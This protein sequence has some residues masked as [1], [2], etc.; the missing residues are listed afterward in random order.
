MKN[1]FFLGVFLGLCLALNAQYIERKN[2]TYKNVQY[3]VFVIKVDS[4]VRNGFTIASNDLR[5][6]ESSYFD[7]LAAN[8]KFFAV[9]ASIVDA[10]CKPLGLYVLDGRQ[11][12]PVNLDTGSGNFFILPNGV[13]S[14]DGNTFSLV[15]SSSY[16][17]KNVK[18]AIQSGPML[19]ISGKI[20]TSLT[21]GSKNR[22]LR[23]GVGIYKSGGNDFLVFAKSS[24]VVNF[25][26]FADFFLKKFTC[27]NALN[28]ESGANCS[29]HLPRLKN[30]PRSTVVCNYLVIRF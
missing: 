15:E 5:Q 6:G 23:C 29:M 11:V 3:D 12:S 28:L 25:Y 10:S 21:K 26:D 8:G 14:F 17:A 16:S 1:L 22:N 4:F 9:T 7:S 2:Y 18:Y 13:L 27:N 24:T 19:V 30:A 20:S